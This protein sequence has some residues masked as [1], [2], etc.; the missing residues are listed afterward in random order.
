MLRYRR[1]RTQPAHDL[2][3]LQAKV[4]AMVLLAGVLLTL[5][6]PAGAQADFTLEPAPALSSTN[7]PASVADRLQAEGSRLVR[8]AGG[9]N[10]P[11]CDV[12]WVKSV[13][14]RKPATPSASDVLYSGLQ[15]GTPMGVLRFLSSDAEDFHDQ[16]LKPGF[17]TMRY[18]LV[19]AGTSEADGAEY[20][21][22]LLLSPMEGD[23]QIAKTLAFD[24]AV[25]LSLK[26]SGTGH[27][28]LMS[29]VAPNPA[30]KLLPA[31]V[32]DDRGNC[33]VQVKLRDETGA[34]FV[35]SILVVTPLK[36]QGGS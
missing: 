31:V 27:P 18:T 21:D 26:A 25:Q 12:W 29:L 8:T 10:D 11:I 16:K 34:A 3:D 23:S 15:T 35:L 22:F 6:L 1:C 14:T 32:S 30:Y 24:K 28:A 5:G 36:E 33:A 2:R 7:I 13:P 9:G 17:Y 4:R 19:Q 20:R